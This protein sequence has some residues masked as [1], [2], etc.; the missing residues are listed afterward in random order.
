MSSLFDTGI[1]SVVNS[2]GA[3]L[4]G[5][6]L[7]FYTAGTTTPLNTYSDSAL[8][9]P[10]SNPVVADANGRF[11]DI[12]LSQTSYKYILKTS[13]DVTLITQ[14]N[15]D[16]ALALSVISGSTGASVVGFIQSGTG[17]V[18]ST[19]QTELRRTVWIDNYLTG[20]V[21]PDDAL[22]LACAVGNVIELGHGT[23][24]SFVARAIIPAGIT[25]RMNG[26]TIQGAVG[27]TGNSLIK[28]AGDLVIEGPGFFNGTNV[29]APAGAYASGDYAGVGIYMSGTQRGAV[30]RGITFSNFP[31]GPILNDSAS[32]PVAPLVTDCRF[33][34]NQ[35]YASNETNA[36]VHFHAVSAGVISDCY[37]SGYNWKGFYAA[38]GSYNHITRCHASGGVVGH[39]SHYLSGGSY[40]S[41]EDCTHTGTGFGVKCYQELKPTVRNFKLESG[42]AAVYMQGC[43]DLLVDGVWANDPAAQA[44]LIEGLAS[45]TAS[46]TVRNVR[47]VRSSAGTTANHVGVYVAGSSTGLI[48]GLTIENCYLKNMLW[49]IYI[50]N[51]GVAQKDIAIRNNHLINTGQ[52]GVF[53][54]IGSGVISGNLIEMD[55]A[56]VEAAVFINRDSVTTDGIIEI[57]NNQLRNCDIDNIQIGAGG[58]L[59]YKAIIVRNN[60]GSGGL[61]FLN[62]NGNANAADIVSY[63]EVANNEFTSLANGCAFTFNTTTSTKLKYNNNVFLDASYVRVADTY[64]N[65]ANV[66][67]VEFRSQRG[68]VTLSGGTATATLPIAEP[69]ANYYV[70]IS[71]NANETFRWSSKTTSQFT[72]TSSNAGSTAIVDWQIGRVQ[73]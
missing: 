10:N 33:L 6:K 52:Y 50:I 7:Y 19:V 68:T 9:I 14:D 24:Y 22:E 28:A 65:L 16:P 44:V 62:Y 43:T 21:N 56:A 29:P 69:D 17:A 59:A 51:S 64:T 46:G 35:T 31:S 71:G 73:G 47:A 34:T 11:P 53:A 67:L 13:A 61:K 20:G 27:F 30:I 70:Q 5:A 8:T 1:F 23:T 72:I 40:N 57:S 36:L 18:A 66:T 60:R 54:Y 41:I 42:Y 55:G 32:A 58:R 4:S 37:A 25:I 15:Y 12:Y 49:G 26:A 38:A 39:A 3:P 2:A 63:L 48:D 45:Y